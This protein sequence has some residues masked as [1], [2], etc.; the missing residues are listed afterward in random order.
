MCRA[1]ELPSG[2]PGLLLKWQASRRHGVSFPARLYLSPAAHSLMDSQGDTAWDAKRWA[3]DLAGAGVDW[4]QTAPKNHQPAASGSHSVLAGR[5]AGM[6]WHSVA[7]FC[8]EAMLPLQECCLI[9]Q[10]VQ[11]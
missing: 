11:W 10:D 3:F 5:Y 6:A 4:S 8:G 2:G 9:P 7:D 1:A